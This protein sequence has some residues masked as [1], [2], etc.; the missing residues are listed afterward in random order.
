[1]VRIE[2][3]PFQMDFIRLLMN[4]NLNI[5]QVENVSIEF[6]YLLKA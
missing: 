1:M 6:K 2:R 5:W 4:L 3:C